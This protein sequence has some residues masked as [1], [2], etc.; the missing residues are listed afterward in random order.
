[1]IEVVNHLC[2]VERHSALG[3]HRRFPHPIH[4]VTP[5]A[6]GLHLGRGV[7]ESGVARHIEHALE[8][9]APGI[10]VTAFLLRLFSDQHGRTRVDLC[11]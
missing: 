8:R 10:D 4:A 6:I 3:A 2:F 1:M 7:E 5:P 9:N 11:S